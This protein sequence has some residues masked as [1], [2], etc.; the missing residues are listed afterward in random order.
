MT[1]DGTSGIS[2]ERLDWNNYPAWAAN[3]KFFL[4]TKK[5]WHMVIHTEPAANAEDRKADEL[6]L[7]YIGLCVKPVHQPTI[8]RCTT[9]NQAWTTLQET[10]AAKT[11]ARK[12]QLRRDPDSALMATFQPRRDD[13]QFNHNS[14]PRNFSRSNG[15]RGVSNRTRVSAARPPNI[16]SPRPIFGNHSSYD[17]SARDA[18]AYAEDTCLY[19]YKPGHYAAE[20]KKKRRDMESR[21]AGH[22]MQ[23]PP[24]HNRNPSQQYSAIAFT[25]TS[26]S[27]T[28]N[29][30]WILDTGATRHITPHKQLLTDLRPAPHTVIVTFGNGSIGEATLIGDAYLQPNPGSLIKLTDVLY[31]PGAA[32]NLL[33]VSQAT[34]RGFSFSFKDTDCQIS[35]D[36]QM[37]ATGHA[38]TTCSIYHLASRCLEPGSAAHAMTTAYAARA[39]TPQLWHRRLGHLGYDNLAKLTNMSTG[40]N[41]TSA[42]IKTTS[43]D[44]CDACILGKQHRLPFNASTTITSKPLE[45]LHTDLCGP[46]PVPSH[47][48]NLYFI[49]LLDDHTGYSLISPL[50]RKSDAAAFLKTSITMLERQTGYTVKRIRSDNGG[51]FINT[52]LDTFYQSKGIKSET[53]VP[54]TPQQNG[55]AERLNRTLL[56]KARPMLADANLPK[57]LWAEAIVTANYLRNRSPI[58]S[59][60]TTPYELFHGTKPDLSHLRTFG[61]RAYA[62]VPTVLRTKLDAVSEPGRF[63]GYP[64][65]TKGYKILLDNGTTVISRDV[66]FD[67]TSSMLPKTNL[68][69]TNLPKT[70]LPETIPFS[71]TDDNEAVGAPA[72]PEAPPSPPIAL[73][74]TERAAARRPASLWQDDAYRITDRTTAIVNIATT[75]AEPTSL[76]EALQSPEAD[77]WRLAM[78]EEIASLAANDTWTLQPAPPSIKPIPV[79]WVYKEKRDANGNIER[80]KARLVVKGFHQRE[81]IDYDEVFAPVSKYS[82][83]R[84]VLAIAADLDLEIHQLDIKTAFLNGKLDEDVYIQQPPG[85]N[86]DNPDLACKLNKALYGLKQASRAWHRTLKTEIESMGF[87]EST[88]DPGLFIKPSSPPAYLLIYVDDILVITNNTSMLN[89]V[90]NQISTAFETRDLGPATF[91]LGIDIIR[92]RTTKTIK[93]T[94]TRHTTDL[95]SKFNMEK[96]KPFDTPSSIAIKLTADGEPLDTKEHPYSTLIGSLMY[97]ASCTRPDIA[98]AV[99]ALA[100]YMSKPTTTHWTAAKHVLRYLA[101]TTDYGIIFTPSDSTLNAYCDANHAGDIDTR[102]STTG[103]VFTFNNGAITWSSRLQ[104]TVAASTTEAEYMAA[105]STVKEALWLRKLFTDLDLH[106]ACI[107]IKSD[108]QSAIHMLKNPV[109]SLRSK[110]IDIVHHF[111][112][113]R[114]ARGE[115]NFFYIPTDSM[116]ADILTKP[117]PTNKFKFCRDAMGIA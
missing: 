106:I 109:I 96:S 29:D 54:Y 108:S 3:M 25:A 22:D 47:G 36:N 57:F 18:R 2:V 58:S 73:R 31:I 4:T 38:D 112:R 113:E 5:C 68:P 37:I 110:H 107:D 12:L 6:A 77:Q 16:S 97:L 35:K 14:G 64:A 62:H 20:C 87:K 71:D 19:C 27:N 100:R 102:R 53:S 21:R 90:K 32:D 30:D 44:S 61:A 59:Q 81:G 116:V 48:G 55:K 10:F 72:E 101:G 8:L 94:Q 105:A 26:T 79:K 83:L 28:V 74:R 104:P 23:R 95:L 56:D 82:T 11:F 66:T 40:I 103:Y 93:L 92:D 52:E 51:E 80:H 76:E 45:L 60:D 24:S 98:Q 41:L 91:F 70:N 9:S 99:G 86:Y 63:I 46:M 7:S 1:T 111:A 67:E 75:A 88:A 50:R 89:S 84:T 85:Y 117:V 34:K 33:S 69:K 43:A 42:D 15:P 13:R 49:T 17:R 115:V 65:N 114:V 78:D 39:D